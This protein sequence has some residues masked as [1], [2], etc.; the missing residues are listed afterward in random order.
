MLLLAV[1]LWALI[2]LGLVVF[3]VVPHWRGVLRGVAMTGLILAAWL[4]GMG[5]GD[6][7]LEWIGR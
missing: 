7:V 3:L 6:D 1:I 5:W 4:V 2:A